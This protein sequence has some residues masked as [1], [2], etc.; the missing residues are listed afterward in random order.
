MS[1]KLTNEQFIE[2]AMNIH[3]NKY[4]YSLVKYINSKTKVKIIC[5]IHG[6][7]EQSSQKHLHNKR[8]CQK[9]GGSKKLTTEEFI[10]KSNIIHNNKYDYSLVNY[11]NNSIKV[12][13]ICP[14]HGEFYQ[15]PNNHI[16]KKYG[17]SK[18]SNNRKLTTKEFIVKSDKIHNN[19]YDYSLV[20]YINA[21][22]KVEIICPIHGLFKQSANSHMRGINCPKC[23]ESKGEKVISKLLNINKINHIRQQRFKNCKDKRTLPFDFYL[24]NYNLCIEFDGQQHFELF[25]NFWGGNKTLKL[26]QKHDEIKNQYCLD[27]NI[28]LIRIKYNENIEEKFNSIFNI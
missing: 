20:N 15:N 4:D 24:P 22:T 18:C 8:G 12:K 2:K 7:F 19:K 10:N 16:S 3:N 21:H 27:N 9:C 28:K 14:I 11:I 23:S 26:T 25:N 1:R 13:I 5:P 17:C 6:V